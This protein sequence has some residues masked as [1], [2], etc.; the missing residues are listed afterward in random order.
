M[1]PSG[2]PIHA[3]DY[4]SYG[5]TAAIQAAIDLSATGSPEIQCGVPVYIGPGIWTG[6]PL[7]TRSKPLTIMTAGRMQTDIK[8]TNAAIVDMLSIDAPFVCEGLTISSVV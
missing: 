3:E 6:Q 8:V 4:G 2:K 1:R 5:D 7:S